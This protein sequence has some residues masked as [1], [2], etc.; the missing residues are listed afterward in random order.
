MPP[1]HWP[2]RWPATWKGVNEE[3]HAGDHIE[4]EMEVEELEP[5]KQEDVTRYVNGEKVNIKET[6]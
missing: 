5:E 3:T 2:R 6:A 1:E 4:S